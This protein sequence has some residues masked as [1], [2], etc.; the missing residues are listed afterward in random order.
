MARY[1]CSFIV[2]LSLEDIYASLVDVLQTCNFDILYQTGD[3][4]MAREKPG[5]IPFP[6]LVTVEALVDRSAL[7]NQNTRIDFV[8][9]NE[10]LPLQRD[11]HCWQMFDQVIQ[12]ISD[13]YQWQLVSNVVN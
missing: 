2:T 7:A 10:A 8:V 13:N 3:Y 5:K 1:T 6:Q 11:N 12:V 4:L 9:K